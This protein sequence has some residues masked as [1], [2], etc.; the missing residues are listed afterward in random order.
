M[1]RLSAYGIGIG[2]PSGWEAEISLQQDPSM[3]DAD[4][5]PSGKRLVVMHAANFW[6]PAERGDY[7][8]EAVH[9]M[10]P[11]GIFIALV[12]FD[13]AAA[14]TRL[15]EHGGYPASLQPDDFSPARLQRPMRGQAGLQRFFG[16][17]GRAFCLHVVLG[18]YTLRHTLTP[19]VNGFL[20][21]LTIA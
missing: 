20:S 5:S 12:E 11:E 19:D 13:G 2:V 9:E 14:R 18:A 16:S 10:G 21:G 1:D 4:L 15:F 8:S 6:M 3:F 7:G 17:S